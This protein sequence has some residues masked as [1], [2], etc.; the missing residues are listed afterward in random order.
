M[1]MIAAQHTQVMMQ[2]HRQKQNAMFWEN[3]MVLK[4]VKF[5]HILALRS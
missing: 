4:A 1:L 3:V 2:H 5:A